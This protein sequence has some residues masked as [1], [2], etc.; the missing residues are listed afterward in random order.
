MPDVDFQALYR[1]LDLD[2]CCSPGELRQAWR[3]R[4][5]HIH[6]DRGAG[7][8]AAHELQELNALYSAA[9]AFERRHGR[10]PGAP[11]PAARARQPEARDAPA[12][13]NPSPAGLPRWLLAVILGL[14]ILAWL[15]VRDIPLWGPAAAPAPSTEAGR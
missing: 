13:R 2:P 1:A 9:R 6:P 15:G 10:L 3:R 7:A 11:P 14:L 8:Q 4:V 12:D 5:A